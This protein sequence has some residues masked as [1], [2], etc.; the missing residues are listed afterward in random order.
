MLKLK[1]LISCGSNFFFILPPTFWKN[2]GLQIE[3]VPPPKKYRF[4]RCGTSGK[5]VEITQIQSERVKLGF[6]EI[7]F[8]FF[9]TSKVLKMYDWLR[10]CASVWK[11]NIY[12]RALM[13]AVQDL[14]VNL[15]E[16]KF[17]FNSL[18][19]FKLRKVYNKLIQ[20]LRN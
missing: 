7:Y 18:A 5:K 20:F 15:Q 2:C 14:N 6:K 8:F 19:V 12:M 16:N 10:F 17:L 9:G 4:F 13:E 11:I 3:I 1:V